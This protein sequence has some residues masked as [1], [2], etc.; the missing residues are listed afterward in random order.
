MNDFMK[1]FIFII[2]FIQCFSVYAQRTIPG[3]VKGAFIWEITEGTEQGKARWIS[4]LKSI[5]DSGLIM[6]GKYGTINN[7]PALFFSED[8]NNILRRTVNLGNLSSFSMFTVC[9]KI[10]TLSERAI[11]SLENDSIAELVLTDRRI[12]ALDVYKYSSYTTNLRLTP[13]IVSYIQ[14]RPKEKSTVSRRLQL[15]QPP[16]FQQL[17]VSLFNGTI[18]ELIIF[19]RA[20][21]PV[22]RQ[23]V[24]SYL[25]LK[26]GI[27]LNQELP[28]S[29]L[30]SDG[31]VIWDAEKNAAYNRNIA[32]FGRDDLS[33]LNQTVSESVLSPG[34]MK[35][36]VSGEL[37]NNSFLTWGDNGG[38]LHFTEKSGLRKLN[39]DW[40]ICPFSFKSGDVNIEVNEFSLNEINPLK[41]GESYWLM[42]DRT[43]TGLY[44]F[45]QT[46]YLQS[47]PLRSSEHLI[48]FS[49]VS[50]DADSSGA[51]VYTL[52]AAPSFF[53]RSIVQAPS[54]LL[55]ESGLIQ[56]EIAGGI[57]PFELILRRTSDSRFHLYARESDR[58][59]VFTGISQGE[60]IL[61]VTDAERKSYS[62]KIR[63]SNTHLW[64]CSIGRDYLLPEGE[65]IVLDASIGMPKVNYFYS[66]TTPDGSVINDK[67]LTINQS[68][69]YLLSVTDEDNCNSILE[70][71]IR[72]TGRSD[73][74]GVELYPNPTRGWFLI[75]IS[76]KRTA[77]VN[78]VI[79]DNSGTILKQSLLKE[80]RFYMYSD[81]IRQPGIYFI[82]LV[83][84]NE[85]ESLKLIVQ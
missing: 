64:E 74:E 18:P 58:N 32:G 7:N 72:E 50:I 34:T 62:E 73:I 19:S 84:A 70:I 77:N 31:Q 40:K 3:G 80:D 81:I 46:E 83:L 17:P 53:T 26:Y 8:A 9:Q 76:L 68:G 44:P 51:D 35:L 43:G 54:C 52:L 75:R 71:N 82:N 41:E 60:Y 85:K 79:T 25:A 4:N 78:V 27:S 28:R 65:S 13:E 21:S 16:R 36:S 33:G 38:A 69:I 67:E 42:T 14:N 6:S 56:T 24:E 39:R 37:N 61:H 20:L 5:P 66:W 11:V 15:G 23:Q 30:N 2:A 48:K 47:L 59:H 12:A 57:P 55:P 63:V 45:G 22:E 29:Y 1:A 49:P 10:D